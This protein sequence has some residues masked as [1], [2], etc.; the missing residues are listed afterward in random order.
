MQKDNSSNGMSALDELS[1]RNIDVTFLEKKSVHSLTRRL[2]METP[3]VITDFA[4]HWPAL[5]EWSPENLTSRFGKKPVRVY[6]ASFGQPG[7]QYMDST[8]KVTFGEFV[9]KIMSGN[10]DLRMFL[11]NIAQQIP[12]MVEDIRFPDLG[13]SFSKR[14][15][16]TFFGCK[17]STTP[18]H[19]DIDMSSVFYTSILGR[20]RVRL[21]SPQQSIALYKHPFTV[22]SYVNLDE[23]NFSQHEYLKH[24]K[25]YEVVLEEGET[26]FI[27]SGY[28]HEFNYLDS[29]FGVSLRAPSPRLKDKMHGAL[30]LLTLSPIDRL[31]NKIAPKIW[32]L[33][34]QRYARN[35]ASKLLEVI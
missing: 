35:R 22:R 23:P 30:N 18:L 8:G 34:K 19:Y 1:H 21:F 6:D 24:A 10:S 15:I 25:G 3:C 4:S 20:R 12:E 11:Y 29:G 31:A 32:F 7:N 26:L 28:W 17:G 13:F 2:L 9:S 16:Y 5:K 14:F 27:P 33:W